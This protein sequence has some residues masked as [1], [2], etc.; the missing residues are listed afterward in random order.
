MKDILFKISNLVQRISSAL[1]WEVKEWYEQVWCKDLDEEICCSGDDRYC[2]CN[3]I[4]RRESIIE[5][6][7]Y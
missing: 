7:I 3:G 6:E 1:R 4:T 2:G 5:G